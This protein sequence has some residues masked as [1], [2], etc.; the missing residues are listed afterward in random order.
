MHEKGD[1]SVVTAKRWLCAR[2]AANHVMQAAACSSHGLFMS[3]FPPPHNPFAPMR[4]TR[5][6]FS[7][8]PK[9]AK[10]T[11]HKTPVLSICGETS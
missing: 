5:K 6:G 1:I 4:V 3:E 2:G 7:R 8:C 10:F 9:V 11:S